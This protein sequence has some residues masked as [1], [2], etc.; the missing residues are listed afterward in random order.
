LPQAYSPTA[1]LWRPLALW[2][3]SIRPSPALQHWLTDPGS[4]T[5]R[6]VAKSAGQFRVEIVRQFIGRASRNECQALGIHCS[7][8]ALIREVILKGNNQPWIFARSI[9][10]LASLTGDLRHLRKQHTRPL[11]A[12]LF[13]QSHLVRSPIAVAAIGRNHRYVPAT[14]A[15]SELLWGRRSVFSLH[16]KPLLVSEVFLPD[17]VASLAVEQ[18]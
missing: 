11:G 15:K 4:L 5:A 13:S 1:L 10:P 17:F 14:L 2:P 3:R 12:F 16:D 6:L 8:L 7:D 18:A 9:L